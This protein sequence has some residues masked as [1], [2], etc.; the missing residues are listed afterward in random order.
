[1]NLA[2][3]EVKK[4]MNIKFIQLEKVPL[5]ILIIAIIYFV[6]TASYEI[7]YPGL[8]YDETLFVNGA[9]GGLDNSFIHKRIFGIPV[10]LM[11]YIG[12]VKAWLF[13]PIFHFLGVSP[14]TIRI[15]VIIISTI[16]L[17][18][19]F[20]LGEIIFNK[21]I[22]SLIVIILATDPSFIYTSRLDW[23]PVV[24]MNFFKILT[25]FAFFKIISYPDNSPNYKFIYWYILLLV[26]L[27]LGLWDKLNFI[28]FISGLF[29]CSAVFYFKKIVKIWNVYKSQILIPTIAFVTIISS[30]IVGL[31]IPVINLGNKTSESLSQR[32]FRLSNAYE[33]TVSGK[34]VYE[35]IFNK[36]LPEA[37]WVNQLTFLILVFLLIAL[38]LFI[39]SNSNYKSI[40]KLGSDIRRTL[41]FF[42]LLFGLISM[43]MVATRQAGGPHHIMMLFPFQ[44]FVNISAVL[45]SVEL[46]I[47]CFRGV[48]KKW[49]R[50]IKIGCITLVIIIFSNFIN[51][52]IKVNNRY[53]L[54]LHDKTSFNHRWTP[55]I[56]KLSKYL[57]NYQNEV[58]F[59]VSADWGFHTQLFGLAEAES[60]SK[61]IDLW[62]TFNDLHQLSDDEKEKTYEVFFKGKNILVLLHSEKA[63]IM[64]FSRS[65]FLEFSSE[66]FKTSEL[67]KSFTN[68]SNEFIYEIYA[69]KG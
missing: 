45:V 56:Y 32:F 7:K 15:P 48:F 22:A 44:H 8:Y 3:E 21:W 65:N 27:V 42:T 35:W 55:A 2:S 53:S 58:D 64:K 10:M 1:M 24:F 66:F 46:I 14:E 5:L 37:T 69:V 57:N 11:S 26:A 62:P 47:Q 51:S 52:Q 60:R 43:Q 29:I 18:L 20:Y 39:S 25:L 41:L 31:I 33:T 49:E 36:S 50:F 16:T 23:G 67:V 6:Y 63:E 30:M 4:N 54:A 12:A 40:I 68:N 38:C 34:A 61:Y 28:W 59:I 19:S 17:I 13:Y 9:L